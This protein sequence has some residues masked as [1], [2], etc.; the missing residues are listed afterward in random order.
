[1]RT[2]KQVIKNISIT[3]GILANEIAQAIAAQQKALDSLA[4]MIEWP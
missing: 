3:L 4:W 1:M 2:H